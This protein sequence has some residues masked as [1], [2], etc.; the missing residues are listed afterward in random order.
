MT[1]Y[2]WEL[3]EYP[4]FLLAMGTHEDEPHFLVAIEARWI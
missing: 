3:G 1:L 4:K 2:M